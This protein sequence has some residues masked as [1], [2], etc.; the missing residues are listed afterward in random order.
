MRA[1]FGFCTAL[2]AALFAAARAEPIRLTGTVGKAPVFLELDHTGDTVSGWYFHLKQGKQIRL[3]GK[4]DRHGFFQLDEYV[5]ATNSRTGSFKGRIRDG[6]WSGTWSDPAAKRTLS[7]DFTEVRGTLRGDN[8]RLRCTVKKRD[9]DFGSRTTQSLDLTLK[10]GRVKALKLALSERGDG[11]DEQNCG[12]E[13]ADLKQFPAP[14]GILLK[15]RK[16]GGEHR[17]SVRLYPAGRFLVVRIGDPSQ[18]GDDCRG[19]GDET[20]CSPRAFWLGLAVNRDT[21]TCKQIK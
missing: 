20:F 2:I 21:Q 14:A 12:L 7:A 16:A 18:A 17:C 13:L 8:G 1:A 9:A 6:A 11:D 10:Q 4:L 15:A 3:E 5:A 19:A